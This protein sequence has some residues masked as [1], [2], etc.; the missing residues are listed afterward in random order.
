MGTC[1]DIT[2]TANSVIYETTANVPDVAGV[3]TAIL[4]VVPVTYADYFEVFGMDLDGTH[5]FNFEMAATGGA[6]NRLYFNYQNAISPTYT[7]QNITTGGYARPIWLAMRNNAGAFTT[8]Y[9]LD[10]GDF[11]VGP[12]VT[13]GST[14][15]PAKM[16]W[17]TNSAYAA[18]FNGHVKY[19]F[20]AVSPEHYSLA[21]I[22]EQFETRDLVRKNAAFNFFNNCRVGDLMHINQAGGR[23]MTRT[24]RADSSPSTLQLPPVPRVWQMAVPATAGAQDVSPSSID[25]A[26]SVS[27]PVV[28]PGAVTV[29]PSSI[30]TAEAF[31]TD[32]ITL[33]LLPSSIATAEDFGTP[34]LSV[35]AVTVAPDSITSAEAFGTA[36]LSPVL[37]PAS[38][39][40]AEAFGT[41]QLNLAMTAN[42]IATAESV[43]TD[44]TVALAPQAISADSIT[45]AEGFGTDQLNLF[46]TMNSITSAE[47]VASPLVDNG[48]GVGGGGGVMVR[49][50]RGIFGRRV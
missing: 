31:G 18:T 12:T 15:A 49:R 8:Y 14:F 24:G 48:T 1:C 2:N 17:S 26:E 19:E 45:S 42:S 36:S 39:D 11:T 38:V 13:F 6:G 50:R 23:H 46:L 28:T 27:S 29:A 44:H 43:P 37:F 47:D 40:T 34:V 3:F 9:Q 32:L 21:Q 22:K 35:G 30:D 25:T 41:A 4:R 5:F 16:Y 20:L 10:G 7:E 33:Y